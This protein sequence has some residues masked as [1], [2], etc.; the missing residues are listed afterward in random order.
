MVSHCRLPSQGKE[1]TT[2]PQMTLSEKVLLRFSSKKAG[3]ESGPGSL[4]FPVAKRAGRPGGAGLRP[5]GHARGYESGGLQGGPQMARS[6][7]TAPRSCCHRRDTCGLRGGEGPGSVRVPTTSS[8]ASLKPRP[9]GDPKPQPH[10]TPK[11]CRNS[12]L[13]PICS[14]WFSNRTPLFLH[15]NLGGGG[16][17]SG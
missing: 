10:N 11:F 15:T 8:C 13:T 4:S 12:D 17:C 3:R 16:G 1:A 6:S 7:G 5:G 14:S 9:P 2:V